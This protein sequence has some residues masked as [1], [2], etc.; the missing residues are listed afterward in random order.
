VDENGADEYQFALKQA[1]EAKGGPVRLD[2]ARAR[3]VW[4]SAAPLPRP[5]H[6]RTPPPPLPFGAPDVA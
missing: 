5:T 4:L 6:T 2:H 3:C 1:K